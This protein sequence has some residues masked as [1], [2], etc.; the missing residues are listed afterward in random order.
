MQSK[1][2]TAKT[3]HWFV[4][5]GVTGDDQFVEQEFAVWDSLKSTFYYR[6]LRANWTYNTRLPVNVWLRFSMQ[7]PSGLE[8]VEVARIFDEQVW[9]PQFQPSPP[10]WL[11]TRVGSCRQPVLCAGHSYRLEHSMPHPVSK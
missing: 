4:K 11:R 7:A 10:F 5:F 2:T 3:A 8:M 1:V 6:A 9:S